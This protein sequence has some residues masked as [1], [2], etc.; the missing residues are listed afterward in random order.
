MVLARERGRHAEYRRLRDK[1]FQYF[2]V[3]DAV[4]ALAAANVI[5]EWGYL[6][7]PE[8]EATLD[9]MDQMLSEIVTAGRGVSPDSLAVAQCYR[10]QLRLLR[11]DTVGVAAALEYLTTDPAARSMA[12]SRICAPFLE[13]L[14]ARDRSGNFHAEA[15]RRLFDVMEDRPMSLGRGPGMFVIETNLSASANLELARSLGELGYPESGLQVVER[16]PYQASLWGLYGFHV[17]FVREEARLLAQAGET[18][19]ALARYDKYFRL[20]PEPPDLESWAE[21]WEAVRTEFAALKESA[22]G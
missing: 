13:F 21:V 8:S 15:A 12:V 1:L 6:G 14:E 16:R 4:D 7:E 17:D 5:F 10:A 11:Q 9:A 3:R 20:R 19:A 18:E 2:D 22:A